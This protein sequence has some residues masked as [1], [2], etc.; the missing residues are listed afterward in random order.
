MSFCISCPPFRLRRFVYNISEQ[1]R[2][3]TTNTLLNQ[4]LSGKF[5]L[6]ERTQQLKILYKSEAIISRWKRSAKIRKE[7]ISLG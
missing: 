6:Q 4:G 5:S 7:F 1:K 2:D 3:F